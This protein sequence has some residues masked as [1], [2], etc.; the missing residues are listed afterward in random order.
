MTCSPCCHPILADVAQQK[1]LWV[2]FRCH[3]QLSH[4]VYSMLK[5]GDFFFPCP[6]CSAVNADMLQLIVE[7][8]KDLSRLQCL[9]VPVTSRAGD[10]LS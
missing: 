6:H 10:N 8:D 2:E 4:A 7:G 9:S 1:L 5:F 3:G